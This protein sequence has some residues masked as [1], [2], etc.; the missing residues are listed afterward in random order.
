MKNGI[1]F[2]RF[3]TIGINMKF[4]TMNYREVHIKYITPKNDYYQ[5]SF[6]IKRMFWAHQKHMIYRKL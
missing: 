3:C 2:N 6:I 1:F 5:G 4:D